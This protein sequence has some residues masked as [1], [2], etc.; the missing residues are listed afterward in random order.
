MDIGGAT[1]TAGSGREGG[2][3]ECGNSGV[4]GRRGGNGGR[5]GIDGDVGDEVCNGCCV[6]VIVKSR[7]SGGSEDDRLDGVNSRDGRG[8]GGVLWKGERLRFVSITSCLNSSSSQCRFLVRL[9]SGGAMGDG[10][11]SGCGGG[12]VGGS[13]DAGGDGVDG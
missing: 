7:I 9:A 6:M 13:D 12:Y 2:V 3:L 8:M 1:G 10:E 11:G 5:G 4:G